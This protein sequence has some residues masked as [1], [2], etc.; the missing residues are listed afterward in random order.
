MSRQTT[1]GD[2][3]PEQP[4]NGDYH[5]DDQIGLLIRRAH[6]RA[7]AIFAQ[8]FSH[9]GL[10]PLQFTALIKIRDEGRVSQNQLGRLV[11]VDPSTIMGVVARL[12]DRGFI[13]R[14][15]DPR[16]K[17]RMLLTITSTGL[18]LAEDLECVG[19]EVTRATL[20]P[21]TMSER[22]QLHDLLSKLN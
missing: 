4:Q 21:L 18:K 9:S 1:S 22:A 5:V 15:P 16:D 17:R 12:H 10:S 13:R 3:E 14:L 19:H 8:H 11:F 2:E 6:Q 20:A 7:S